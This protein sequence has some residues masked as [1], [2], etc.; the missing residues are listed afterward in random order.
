MA[1]E[2]LTDRLQQAMSKLRRKGKV[3][4]ADVKEMMRE[5]R[6]ALLEADV[7]LQVVKE[8]T[9]NVRERAIGVEVLDSLSPAQQIV[10]IVDEELTKTLGSETVGIE[11]SPKIPTI[12]MM[13]GLQGAGKTT[14]AGK[15]ANHLMK[16]ENARP[17]MIAADIYRPAAID[18]LKVL[19]Q[20][21]NVPVFDMGTDVSPVEIVRQGLAVAKE[22]KN[23]YVL[24]DTAG[25]LHIDQQ[26]MDEL[27]QIKD[28]AQPNEILL[29]VDAMTGQD[30]VNVAES[31]NQQLGITGV[32]ITKLDGDTRGGAALSIRQV[33]GAPIKFT[34]TGE[35][36]TDLEVFH[37]DRMSSR[38]LGMG[39]MLTL[40]EKA[41]QDYDEKKAEELAQKM[42]ENS[43]DF[44]D[45]V[46]QIDQVMGMGPIEDLLKMIPGM[47]QMPGIENVKVD[48]KQIARQ[49]AM[50]YS[51][52]PAERENPDL[53]NPSRRRRI[54]AGSGNSVVEV[55]RMIKQFK[56]SRKMMQQMSKGNMNIPGMDQMFGGGVKGKLG[57]MAMNRMVKKQKKKKKKRK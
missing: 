19:G 34:G 33:T 51:M 2:S 22:K 53:L 18:Q 40:I 24:I 57:K 9:K 5:I 15:L 3:T 37:P 8:F 41:Q 31:F 27:K 20:Q 38:I 16:T 10:K 25:R 50:V 43:F 30:A 4:E 49:K 12:I 26:L 23:D 21:L 48:P 11:K 14:F 32:V 42:K 36:L 35:K 17:L 29:V 54:A 46:E 52:T 28:L 39:D 44:N 45:F 13:A 6:L 1:F 7:N 56:E 47:S 55:N